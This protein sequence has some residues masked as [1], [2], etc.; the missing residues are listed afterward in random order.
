MPTAFHIIVSPE[1][2]SDLESI[3]SYIA[4]DS[5]QNASKTATRILDAI[6]TLE[7]FPHRTLAE[8]QNPQMMY[9]VRSLPVKPYII[10]FR[11]LDQQQAVRIL[12]IRHGGRR[13]PVW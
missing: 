11:V 6:A 3:C 13:P 8:H 10:Y 1:S 7:F 4:Q 9:P 12:A 5:P 2:A